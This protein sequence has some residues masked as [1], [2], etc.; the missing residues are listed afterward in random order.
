MGHPPRALQ[1]RPELLPH[2]QIYWGIY[3]RLSKSRQWDQ[4]DPQSITTQE[5]FGYCAAIHWHD[6]DR[7]LLVLDLVQAMDEVFISHL[8]E[9][10]ASAVTVD[11]Q[12]S[13]AVVTK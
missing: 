10:R 7:K 6:V 12:A 1:D 3:Q 13:S 5:C 9:V 4:G 11:S 8:K 2:L